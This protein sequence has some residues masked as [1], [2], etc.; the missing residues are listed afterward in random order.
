MMDLLKTDLPAGFYSGIFRDVGVGGDD[1]HVFGQRLGHQQPPEGIPVD[2]GNCPDFSTLR[3]V[4]ER[5]G[6]PFTDQSKT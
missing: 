3:S 2:G 5:S 6:N 1:D 4:S